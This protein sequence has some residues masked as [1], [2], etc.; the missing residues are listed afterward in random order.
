MEAM[1]AD[2]REMKGTSGGRG[3]FVRVDFILYCLVCSV[4]FHVRDQ[5][6]MYF[7]S[8]RPSQ[9]SNIRPRQ[10]A[11]HRSLEGA[12]RELDSEV[13]ELN[14]F[15]TQLR[16]SKFWLEERERKIADFETLLGADA[17]CSESTPEEDAASTANCGVPCLPSESS[18]ITAN[19]RSLKTMQQ[20]SLPPDD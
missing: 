3:P 11:R 10:S 1:V 20:A 16:S 2:Q 14:R 5:T 18:S 15:I 7:T 12:K 9:R 13:D 6:R 17:S 8:C 4:Q 19:L